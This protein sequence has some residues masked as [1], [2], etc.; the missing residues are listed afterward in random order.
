M[1][2]KNKIALVIGYICIVLSLTFLIYILNEVIQSSNRAQEREQLN[3]RVD[4]IQTFIEKKDS[5]L[6]IQHADRLE[7]ILKQLD[8][9]LTL[10]DVNDQ[11]VYKTTTKQ[12][13]IVKLPE[14]T[15]TVIRDQRMIYLKP[16]QENGERMGTIVLTAPLIKMKGIEVL[17]LLIFAIG[18]GF[19]I[20]LHRTRIQY[21]HPIRQVTRLLENLLQGRFNERLSSDSKME[22]ISKL[23]HVT[24]ML[25]NEM[26]IMSRSYMYQKGRM[27]TLIENIG[28]GL[29]FIDGNQKISHINRTFKQTFKLDTTH[30]K[31]SNYEEVIPYEEVNEL[32]QNVFALGKRQSKQMMIPIHIERKH[33][34]VSCAP[35]LD[36]DNHASGIVVVFHDIT[37]LKKLENMRKDFVANVSHELKTPITS[38]IGFTETLLDGAKENKTLEEQF[39]HIILK[40]SKRLQSLISDLLDLSKIEKDHFVINWQK[41]NLNLI[42]EDVILILSDKAFQKDIILI[43]HKS[44]PCFAWGDPYRIRQI[45]INL[46]T[47]AIAYT[48]SKGK[49]TVS[50]ENDEHDVKLIISDTGIGI[51]K[52]HFPRI[53]E[54]F[55]R[56]DKARSRDLGGTGLGLAIVKH[57]VEVHEGHIE[58]DSELGQ[59]T[60][61]TISFKKAQDE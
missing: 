5:Q 44:D 51:D 21:I 43:N 59:G 33:F 1:S 31:R 2:R 39:L 49:V 17:Y 57:L 34:D 10:Y 27:S 55:Y 18:I 28:S 41:V 58:I 25:A 52:K 53:F 14:S 22:A 4:F 6:T 23:N 29:L 60:T 50:L 48:P 16:L 36:N 8:N 11:V 32:I 38:V 47:N 54:R 45:M 40:E 46:I 13:P 19:F 15:E 12:H 35:I 37:E 26:D 30:W 42:V 7:R 9:D 24:N 61:F 3:E 20:L 56:V